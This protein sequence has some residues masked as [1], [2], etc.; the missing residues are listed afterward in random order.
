M[1][2][3]KTTRFS[4]HVRYDRTDQNGKALSSASFAQEMTPTGELKDTSNLD[5]DYLTVLNQP[6]AVELDASTLRDI[7][8][9]VGRVPFDFPSPITGGSVH[10]FLQRGAISRFGAAPV[11]AVTFDA[12]GPMREPLPGHPRVSIRG[13]MRMNGTAYYS[14]RSG[15]L[16]GLDETLTISGNLKEHAE[17]TPVTI[18]Y[19]RSIKAQE[20]PPF[21][22]AA[23]SAH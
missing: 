17:V 5:P 7:R 23:S 3:G 1:R 20:A 15:L 4:A 19:W 9:L 22:E 6:F 13:S 10:G 2:R 18:V 11:I 16:M 21:T 12:L 8:R 14:L